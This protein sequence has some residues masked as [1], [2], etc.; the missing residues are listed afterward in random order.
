MLLSSRVNC[1]FRSVVEVLNIFNEVSDG[2]LGTIPCNNTI[3]NWVKKSG[4]KAYETA[5][6]TL[7]DTDYAEVVDESMMIGSERHFHSFQSTL[8]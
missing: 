2:I 8:H 3:E 4:F 7:Q 1:G 6:E 5:G